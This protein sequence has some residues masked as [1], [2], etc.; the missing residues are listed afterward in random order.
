MLKKEIGLFGVFCMSAGG[1]ISSGLFVLPGIAFA[2]S[3]PAAILAYVLA[4]GLIL[5][6]MLAK[7]ELATAMPKSGG[8]YFFIERG[9]GPLMGTVIGLLGW[10]SLALKAAFALVGLGSLAALV[11]TGSDSMVL[12]ITALIGCGLFTLVNLVSVKKTAGLQNF[13]VLFLLAALVIFFFT[14]VDSVEVARF[15]PFM[16]HGLESVFVVAGMVFIS[17]GGLTKVAAVA[18][19]IKDPG[20]NIPLGMFVAFGV[21]SAFYVGVVFVT[22]GN[23]DGA[24]LAGSLTPLDLAASEAMG[25]TGRIIIG[26]G[27]FLAFATTANAGILSASRSPM[28]MSLDGLVPEVLAKTNAKF[29]TPFIAILGTGGFIALTVA[30]LSVENLVK[31]ASAIMLLMFCLE[32]VA[33]LILRGNRYETWRPTFRTPLFPWLPLASI[34]V[35]G[36]L[37]IEMG[38]VPL[39]LTGAFAAVAV[40]WYM[41]YVRPRIDRESGFVHMVDRLLSK[42]MKR[43]VLE[44]E[45]RGIALERDGVVQDRFDRLVTEG[46]I[47]DINHEI[48]DSEFFSILA[49]R[50]ADR[51]WDRTELSAGRIQQLFLERE[52]ESSTVVAPGV[53]IPHIE[54]PGKNVFEV[55]PV[56]CRPGVVFNN[57]GEPVTTIFAIAASDDERNFHLRA[58][59]AVAHIV[60]EEGFK[61]RWSRAGDPEQLRDVIL[62]AGRTRDVEAGSR[63]EKRKRK[64]E[65]QTEPKLSGSEKPAF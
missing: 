65:N 63:K 15:T 64:T 16:P 55:M 10:L 6:S 39:L 1:M 17:F 26:I 11:F 46:E 40:I 54:V 14:G 44:T 3:G 22:F 52:A 58:L 2:E 5:P 32:N 53:A 45:L 34:F 56:R 28:A 62:L 59:M 19:E 29:G 23:V 24:L 47:L 57:M 8:A 21:V 51:I 4:A 7:A 31:T 61:E 27:A 13:L 30:F 35:Y 36:F 25:Q 43:G 37:I 41:Y 50:M 20:R 12:K 38:P 18:E 48:S 60:R 49:S 42:D 9:L 33:L